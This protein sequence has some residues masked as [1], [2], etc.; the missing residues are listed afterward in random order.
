MYQNDRTLTPEE[1]K[2]VD[3]YLFPRLVEKNTN[4]MRMTPGFGLRIEH[5]STYLHFP[6]ATPPKSTERRLS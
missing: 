6:R 1:Q 5:I 4:M 2:I 3:N